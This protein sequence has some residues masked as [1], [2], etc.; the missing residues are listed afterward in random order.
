MTTRRGGGCGASAAN[1]ANVDRFA[2]CGWG[3]WCWEREP[4]D[5]CEPKTRMLISPIVRSAV[6]TFWGRL[7]AINLHNFPIDPAQY[8]ANFAP[9]DNPGRSAVKPTE[10]RARERERS[11]SKCERVSSVSLLFMQ[12]LPNAQIDVPVDLWD[13]AAP[14]NRLRVGFRLLIDKVIFVYNFDR[15]IYTL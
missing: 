11:K 9:R 2:Y 1:A 14:N 5:I 4:A 10:K 6:G 15:K 8:E 12:I 3:I 13:T 7:L